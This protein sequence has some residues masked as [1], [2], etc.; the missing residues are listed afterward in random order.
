MQRHR[1]HGVERLRLLFLSQLVEANTIRLERCPQILF[2]IRIL[3]IDVAIDVKL[4]ILDHNRFITQFNGNW[5]GELD[6]L[7]PG[8]MFQIAGDGVVAEID[9][10]RFREDSGEVFDFIVS[11]SYAAVR[12]ERSDLGQRFTAV[13]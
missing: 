11:Q 10:R 13:N 7:C 6:D 1:I 2:R 4:A 8:A 5:F 3:V 9:F 12:C